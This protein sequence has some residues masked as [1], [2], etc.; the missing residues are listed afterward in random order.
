MAYQF[1]HIESYSR[2]AGKGKAGGHS[3]RSILAEAGRES[4]NHPHVSSPKPPQIVFGEDLAAVEASTDAYAASVTD[5][6]GRKLR[7]DA[8]VL[9]A[10]VFSREAGTPAA[11]WEKTKRLSVEFLRGQYGERLRSVVEHTDEANPHC[12]FYVVPLPGERFDAVHQGRKAAA[13]VRNAGALKGVQNTAYKTAM[14]NFQNAYSAQVGVELGL[15]KIGPAR[16]RL[17]REQWKI[18]QAEAKRIASTKN[19]ILAGAQAQASAERQKAVMQTFSIKGAAETQAAEIISAAK[20]EAELLKSAAN[21]S[22]S[23][24]EKENAELKSRL[25]RLQEIHDEK[26]KIYGKNDDLAKGR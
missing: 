21:K 25:G 2:S 18:E 11:E 15:T 7:K 8:L 26:A 4:G 14:R 16:R 5:A 3:V 1:I 20:K 13:L 22:P 10:G 9:I 17:T 12:H 6:S 24:L 23:Q 19:E